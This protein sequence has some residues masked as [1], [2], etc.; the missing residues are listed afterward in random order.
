MNE[1]N[2]YN[3]ITNTEAYRMEG[4]IDGLE[5][6]FDKQIAGLEKKFDKLEAKVEIRLTP[7]RRRCEPRNGPLSVA[8]SA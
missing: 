1:P 4:K 7:W 3:G 5:K 6:K 2:G 8:S